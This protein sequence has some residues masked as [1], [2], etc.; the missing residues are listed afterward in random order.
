MSLDISS[1]ENRLNNPAYAKE[2]PPWGKT[3]GL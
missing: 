1:F 2:A 3:K